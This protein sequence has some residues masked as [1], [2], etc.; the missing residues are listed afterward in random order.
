[1]E[2]AFLVYE[3]MTAL[4]LIGPY[5]VLHGLPEAELRFVGKTKGEKRVDSKA[6]GVV[7]D[8]ALSDVPNPDIFVVPGGLAGTMAAA[9]D[10]EILAW[11]RGAHETSTWS[12]SVCTGSLILGA[13]GI[14]GGKT[15]TSHWG[16]V[17][18][19]E[20][21]GA[22]YTAQRVVRDGKV[23]TAAGV[24]SGI[25]MALSLVSNIAGDEIA[26]GIQLSIEYDP[27]PPFDAGSPAKAG[28]ALVEQVTAMFAERM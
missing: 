15:A 10:E 26:K 13:A 4:D 24:S 2:I 28:S 14:L 21:F 12:T 3:G 8:Y 17:D 1:M 19:L 23:M 20:Q 9:A 6:F 22:R 5:E 25:D 11:V 7:V 18:M 16:A 27:Q